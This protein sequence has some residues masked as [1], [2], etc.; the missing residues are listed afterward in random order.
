MFVFC[1]L[2]STA[3]GTSRCLSNIGKLNHLGYYL[4]GSALQAALRFSIKCS[5]KSYP[6]EKI[7]LHVFSNLI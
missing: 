7:S 5:P 1:D 3:V 6:N 2:F 4:E